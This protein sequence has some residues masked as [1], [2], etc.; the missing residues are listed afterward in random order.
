MSKPRKTTDF[1]A[2]PLD[3]S[4]D[5][6]IQ[7]TT[8]DFLIK[9]GIVANDDPKTIINSSDRVMNFIL[10][11]YAKGTAKTRLA[12]YA[13][14]LKVAKADPV[15]IE[16]FS[17]LSTEFNTQVLKVKKDNLSDKT[18][19]NLDDLKTAAKKFMD[20]ATEKPSI[21][22]INRALILALNAL[23]PPLRTEISQMG[24]YLCKNV[25][26]VVKGVKRDENFLVYYE[27]RSK[28]TA[29]KYLIRQ[30][31]TTKS[32]GVFRSNPLPKVVQD[33]IVFTLRALPRAWLLTDPTDITEPLGYDRY[34]TLWASIL[35][36][37][38]TQNTVR[39]IYISDF[40][41]KQHSSND[42]DKLAWQ[43]MSSSDAL[44]GYYKAINIDGGTEIP[45]TGQVAI[46]PKPLKFKPLVELKEAKKKYNNE[47]YYPEH[48]ED[49]A[50]KY[51]ENYQN[52]KEQRDRQNALRRHA[53]YGNVRQSTLDQ[54]G[55]TDEEV[56]TYKRAHGLP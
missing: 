27:S 32:H 10:D 40:L 3:L 20:L 23:V 44:D 22:N 29:M 14:W 24:I 13:Y 45:V 2:K 41:S 4:L 38:Y 34:N 36:V 48:K 55:I 39:S 7:R 33:F 17:S 50:I 6:K 53:I 18:A 37:S 15:L 16:R 46:V 31:K 5:N 25:P 42:K 19:Y 8:L 54:K 26:K 51:S 9:Q 52:N 35:G 21:E 47:I 28:V 30:A 12:H 49:L 43:M 56:E 1:K 11:R